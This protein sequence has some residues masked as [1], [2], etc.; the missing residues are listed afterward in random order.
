MPTGNW[1]FKVF[2]SERGTDEINEWMNGLPTKAR[3]AIDQR[4]NY[5]K[6]QRT[7]TTND[8]KKYV[9]IP[10]IFEIRVCQ[11]KV[12]YRILG[13]YGPDRGT[14]ILLV[15]GIEKGGK[16]PKPMREVAK[17][18]YKLVFKDKKYIDEYN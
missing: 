2:V 16:L 5:L 9:G 7:W 1:V 13:C 14:F 15:G 4:I 10:H 8:C 3:V 6:T 12:E 18:R 11:N 17:E